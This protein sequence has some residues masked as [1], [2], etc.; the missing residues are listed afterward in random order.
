MHVRAYMDTVAPSDKNKCRKRAAFPTKKSHTYA[1]TYAQCVCTFGY[2]L[3]AVR[4]GNTSVYICQDIDECIEAENAA[5]VQSNG[6]NSSDNATASDD[7]VPR[8]DLSRS[9][10]QRVGGEM[11]PLCSGCEFVGDV[12]YLNSF[13][14]TLKDCLDYCLTSAR[15]GAIN[16]EGPVENI[17]CVRPS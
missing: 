12:E 9:G 10:L 6:T 16:F 17:R 5:V 15:C 8:Q 11:H 14:V 2:E 1:H 7:S 3:A 13:A 4:Q